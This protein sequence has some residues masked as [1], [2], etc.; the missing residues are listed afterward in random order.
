MTEKEECFFC[1]II[2]GSIQSKKVY[3]DDH[4]L[5]ILDANPASAGH[6][7]LMP[8]SHY[9]TLQALPEEIG[10]HLFVTTKRLSHTLLR[11]LK[12]QGVSGTSLFLAE[13]KDAGQK[14][15]HCILHIIPRR[16]QDGINLQLPQNQVPPG[17]LQELQDKLK[18][19]VMKEGR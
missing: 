19:S 1:Q 3:E 12:Q 6:I 9:P 11:T 17:A 5:A 8:K 14:A 10:K 15:Q 13:G 4:V 16:E 2:I 18:M 7:L